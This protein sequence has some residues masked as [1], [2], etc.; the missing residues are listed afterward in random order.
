MIT[1]LESL[2][3]KKDAIG[4]FK[5]HAADIGETTPLHRAVE[6]RNL[7]RVTCLLKNGCVQY[8]LLDDKIER[9]LSGILQAKTS[10]DIESKIIKSFLIDGE[11]LPFDLEKDEIYRKIGVTS[12]FHFAAQ[13]GLLELLKSEMRRNSTYYNRSGSHDK[14][15]IQYAIEAGHDELVFFL[16]NHD[17]ILSK[18][19][20]SLP[21]LE[22]QLIR[23]AQ[24]QNQ[25]WGQNDK[26]TDPQKT[27]LH[28][29]LDRLDEAG[30]EIIKHLV[31]RGANFK[32]QDA[33]G[34][35]PLECLR[36]NYNSN[37]YQ[38][39]V[40]DILDYLESKEPLFTR[41]RLAIAVMVT[42]IVIP[43]G[44]EIF[45]PEETHAAFKEFS[46]LLANSP[47]AQATTGIV[48]GLIVMGLISYA[49]YHF[50]NAKP[51]AQPD[52]KTSNTY[53]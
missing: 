34:R 47:A 25:E 32:A 26:N 14:T 33:S 30:F 4:E 45:K 16:I 9:P 42:V 35:T 53:N 36:A 40:R 27:A 5:K 49:I 38:P 13:H 8:D 50:K 51:E 39:F 12:L 22:K 46:E 3:V 44:F 48:G 41:K 20:L 52:H 2:G 7:E 29:I 24:K 37:L 17:P 15:P 6:E 19:I 11:A 18:Q 31:E 28:Y 43:L 1:Y 21:D 10:G 23:R